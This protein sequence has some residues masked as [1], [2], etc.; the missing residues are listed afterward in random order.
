MSLT[1]D[2]NKIC[3]III[4][5]MTPL[6]NGFS[7]TLNVTL[8]SSQP[9]ALTSIQITAD[10]GLSGGGVLSGAN[11]VRFNIW[12]DFNA[13]GNIDS[14]EP[15]LASY[16]VPNN[17][18]YKIG[19]VRNDNRP[20]DLNSSSSAVQA[21]VGRGIS[22]L[23][24]IWAGDFVVTAAKTSSPTSQVRASFKLSLPTKNQR[25]RGTIRDSTGAVVP[26]NAIVVFER[27][28]SSKVCIVNTDASGAYDA[29]LDAGEYQVEVHSAMGNV[30]EDYPK[31]TSKT[32]T[33]G[34][35][36]TVSYNATLTKIAAPK[37]ITGV[38]LDSLGNPLRGNLIEANNSMT[39]RR[40]LTFSGQDGKFS[41]PIDGG[42]WEL[43]ADLGLSGK[44][45][46]GYN[47]ELIPPSATINNL[48][49][50]VGAARPVL[51]TPANAMIKFLLQ[52]SD[53][54]SMDGLGISFDNSPLKA[55]FVI[56]GG[57]VCIAS[58]AGAYALDIDW[59]KEGFI[60]PSNAEIELQ[61]GATPILGPFTI[62]VADLRVRARLFSPGGTP[63]PGVRFYANTT[64]ALG[65]K[66]V[67]EAKTRE[68]GV[69]Q[70]NLGSGE[71]FLLN[72]RCDSDDS[73]P[74][75]IFFGTW[76]TN[77][78]KGSINLGDFR[79]IPL[80]HKVR[81][82]PVDGKNGATLTG[83]RLTRALS[84]GLWISANMYNLDYGVL[85]GSRQISARGGPDD[86]RKND[87]N[88]LSLIKSVLSEDKIQNFFH[89]NTAANVY[90]FTWP[91]ALGVPTGTPSQL[92]RAEFDQRYNKWA[93]NP[94]GNIIQQSIPPGVSRTFY[95]FPVAVVQSH[96]IFGS[97]GDLTWG[98]NYDGETAT[99][100][101]VICSWNSV[102]QGDLAAKS[103]N[104]FVNWKMP[105][106]DSS[107]SNS[108]HVTY[109]DD[110]GKPL[111]GKW[112]GYSMDEWNDV[113]LNHDYPRALNYSAGSATG[114]NGEVVFP[115]Y[116]NGREWEIIDYSANPL[117]VAYVTAK[118]GTNRLILRRTSNAPT[119]QGTV[120]S[121]AGRSPGGVITL[122]GSALEVVGG[123][124][125]FSLCQTNR[126]YG[127]YL[128]AVGRSYAA[129][130]TG[131][132]SVQLGIPSC[133][134]AGTYRIKM[135][136][137][138]WS[139]NTNIFT[140][141][142]VVTGSG[143]NAVAKTGGN[144][145]ITGKFFSIGA[146]IGFKKVGDSWYSYT[147]GDKVVVSDDGTTLKV[148][149]PSLSSGEY[150]VYYLMGDFAGFLGNVSL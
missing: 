145:F 113:D 133:V 1:L 105:I 67:A 18:D 82:V 4:F 116:N 107:Y 141:N 139:M 3:P 50:A 87:T 74:T 147:V 144:I 72:Q 110:M 40:Y 28:D 51:A 137:R 33:L 136:P 93:E 55:D 101:L 57:S 104:G 106:R 148:P 114:I 95:E 86:I 115:A 80:T 47:R 92:S 63:I 73:A 125:G 124:Y 6:Y 38:A 13:N 14:G 46:V 19:G 135:N 45:L 59:S 31:T 17:G 98:F 20:W 79:G 138:Q 54:R 58:V 108:I 26:R 130:A 90:I 7:N 15:L 70:I 121:S 120:I 150:Q 85:W 103:S 102:L 119:R 100:N 60:N 134:P 66:K 146:S 36:A 16:D 88:R 39:R 122:T 42:T 77:G 29:P 8:S 78:L 118:P 96:P 123:G 23:I 68:D 143:G 43:E 84:P 49:A 9:D 75:H 142:F 99:K 27:L 37:T 132:S 5:L 111:G 81:V 24:N 34:A 12:R 69:L 11:S 32:I 71:D 56:S 44:G 25:I 10:V 109:V 129:S 94:D 52:A 131:Y 65:F 117:A 140:T 53:K 64:P 112:I 127:L 61:S 97:G 35:N 62:D 91:K 149:V 41:M 21:E 83:S 2:M 76:L 128:R 126:E 89:T 30:Y 48:T 22:N